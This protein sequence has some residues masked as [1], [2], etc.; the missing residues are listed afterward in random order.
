MSDRS[1]D[2]APAA[3]KVV[4]L[5]DGI[6]SEVQKTE[7]HVGA[8]V[9]KDDDTLPDGGLH[10]WLQVLGSFCLYWNTWGMLNTFGVYQTYY[11]DGPLRDMSPSAIS[12]IGSI[13]SF[14][15]LFVGV[16]SGPLYD[17]GHL[18]S[19][20]VS[21]SVLVVFGMMMTSLCTQ[22][23]QLVLAQAICIGLGTGLL[24]IPSI[25]I[26][27]QYFHRRK[28]L[29]MGLVVSGSSCG[30]V[31]YSI[32]FNQLQPKIG[33]GWTIRVE[34]LISLLT[35]SIAIAILRRREKPSEEIRTLLDLPAFRERPYIF[36]CAALCTSNIAFF[37]PVFYMQPYALVHGLEGQT[38]ALYLVA[39]MNACSILGRLAP[40]LIANKIGPV[41][42]LLCSIVCTGITV[43][44]WIT[45][46]TGWGNITFAAF[47]GF[48][49]GG[50]IALPPIV[51]TSFTKD[52]SRLGTP[53]GGAILNSTGSYLGIQLY[54]GS[55]IMAT[56]CCLLA[57]RFALT[58]KK[59]ITKA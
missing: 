22:Y 12:W 32:V 26:I 54:A 45:T 20:L 53:I 6:L 51:L 11:Q 17:K 3:V 2:E 25:A 49:S 59:M 33:F 23:W 16:I 41:H 43:F 47:F 14:L 58:G 4:D 48:F 55:V 42:T 8:D 10:A 28:A 56:A 29:A 18:R 39:I 13:Q 7:S 36:Y 57:L 15:L 5:N 44:G 31:F 9:T 21:G 1:H 35:L 46:K 38:I 40:S 50:I 27:P 24:Y 34:G 30:G 19:L 37:T 52:L